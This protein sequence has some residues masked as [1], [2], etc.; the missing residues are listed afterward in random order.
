MTNIA[1]TTVSQIHNTFDAIKPA[2]V[3]SKLKVTYHFN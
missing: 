3:V 2:E 1:T